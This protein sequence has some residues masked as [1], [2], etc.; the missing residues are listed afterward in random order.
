MG[1]ITNSAAA[2][3]AFLALAAVAAGCGGGG[4]DSTSEAAARKK[5]E[6]GAQ[7]LTD[8]KSF[9]VRVPIEA[10]VEGK[11]EELGCVNL[12]LEHHGKEERF[13]LLFFDQSCSGGLEAHELI[14]IEPPGLGLERRPGKLDGGDDHARGPRRTR[15][16]TDRPEGPLRGRR[17]HRGRPT[18]GERVEEA[19]GKFV[20]VPVYN[21]EAPA[22]AFP[23]SEDLG[24]VRSNSKRSSTSKGY[25]REL[26]V[27]GEEDGTGATVSDEY[28]RH[29]PGP[30]NQPARPLRSEGPEAAD[31]LESRPR[32][33]L[34]R[35]LDLE[36][37]GRRRA[38]GE[39]EDDDAADRHDPHLAAD[40]LHRRSSAAPP[41]GKDSMSS[42][43][44]SRWAAPSRAPSAM[45]EITS[46]RMP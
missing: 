23:G 17:K 2:I 44:S 37:A 45:K 7:K 12:A 13:D 18:G 21:F 39:E 22:S 25:L 42:S 14:A 19:E 31:P 6:A 8:A 10:E 41:G 29:R 4:S 1:R 27:H 36:P 16:R 5:L 15:R 33:A 35:P 24:D 43:P 30:R 11:I 9:R 32:S 46:G 26:T 34:R 40:D 38:D 3:V 20:D 28:E